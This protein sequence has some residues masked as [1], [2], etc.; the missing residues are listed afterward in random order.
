[1]LIVGHS[2]VGPILEA[3]LVELAHIEER[4]ASWG[5]MLTALIV[6]APLLLGVV[7]LSATLGE[8]LVAPLTPSDGARAPGL[9]VALGLLVRAA[10]LGLVGLVVLVFTLPFLPPLSAC[11]LWVCSKACSCSCCCD[12]RA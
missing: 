8:Q 4:W 10:L 6:A 2:V 5:I 9:F 1:V 3:Q 12:A 11:S 7:Q